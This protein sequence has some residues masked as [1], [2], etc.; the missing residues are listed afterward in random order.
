MKAAFRNLGILRK[1]WPLLLMKARNPI[2]QKWYFFVDK[3]LPFGSSISCKHFQD[4][5]DS[6]AHIVTFLTKKETINYLDDYLFAA[7]VKAM[8]NGQVQTFLNICKQIRF[9]VSLEKTFRAATQLTFLGLLIDTVKQIVC[10]PIEKLERAKLLVSDVLHAKKITVHQLQ[11]LCGFFNFICRAVVPGHAFTRRLYAYTSVSENGQTKLKRGLKPLHHIRVNAEMKSDLK[12]WEVF[13]THLS[14]Y[15]RPFIDFAKTLSARDL[16]MYS[17]ASRNFSLGCGG[18]CQNKY[19]VMQWDQF[20]GKVKSSI[21]YLELYAVTVTVLLWIWKFKNSRIR[22]F[23][24]NESVVKMINKSSSNCKNC[25]VLIRII[26]LEALK[27]NVRVFA[28][29]VRTKLNDLSD[30]LS[31]LQFTR[32]R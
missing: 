23:C 1:H 18:Y 21:E 6:I 3:A 13:L 14:V 15:A 29:H 17:D 31:H 16:D 2:D 11:R 25:M 12:M 32:F 20:T 30:T 9:P 8:C 28:R 22:L 24:D 4:F 5:S 26:T 19:F 27:N 10:I 7:L